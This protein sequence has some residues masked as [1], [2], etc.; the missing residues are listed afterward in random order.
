MYALPKIRFIYQRQ[1][2]LDAL[3][4]LN[5]GSVQDGAQAKVNHLKATAS[6][7]M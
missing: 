2:D 1:S 7:L 5:I 6:T 3:D 4:H